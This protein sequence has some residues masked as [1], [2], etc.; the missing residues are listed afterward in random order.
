LDDP[1][2]RDFLRQLRV[3]ADLPVIEADRQSP[4]LAD[5][6]AWHD[7]GHFRREVFDQL[8]APEV[9]RLLQRPE[10]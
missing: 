4:L 8:V 10:G 7:C 6:R 1:A 9:T 2:I 3:I 5:F